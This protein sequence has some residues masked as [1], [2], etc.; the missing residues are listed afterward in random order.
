[1]QTANHTHYYFLGIG[2]IGMSA[3]ARYLHHNGKTIAGYDKTA[4]SLC[5]QLEK[6]GIDI[7]YQDDF[8]SIPDLF[9]DIETACVIYTPA[10][11]KDFGELFR[12]RESGI[13]LKKRAQLLG[14]ISRTMTCLAVAGTHG[15]TTTSA[16]LAHLLYESGIKMTAFLGGI[17]ND[18]QTNYLSTGTDVMVVEADEFDR[19]F[20]NLTADIAGI[21]AIDADHLDIYGDEAEFKKTFQ[22]FANTIPKGNLLLNEQVDLQGRF[23]GVSEGEYKASDIF[24]KDGAYHFTL[25]SPQGSDKDWVLKLPGRHNLSNAI[26][27]I[28]MALEYGADIALLKKALATFPGVDRRFTYRIDSES[29]V[30]I[31]DYAHHPTEIEAAYKAVREM[32]PRE[33][34]TAVF[35][36]HL[37]SR[38]RDFEAEFIAKLAAFDYLALLDI[39]PARELPIEGVSAYNL[40]QQINALGG[41]VQNTQ[42]IDKADL[43]EY[44]KNR[45]TRIV[46]MIGAG[47]IG[48]EIQ[49]VTEHFKGNQS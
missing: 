15:K 5:Q 12:F 14:D 38:T 46:L 34:I 22:D 31:D 39:Y 36:P 48:V 18:Y 30:L 4:T 17:L 49:K 40:V 28:A 1:M 9:K 10:I 33:K 24:I 32:Y 23:V 35:Q 11:P 20:M 45:G 27:A 2:G 43:I 8:S 6:E 13:T 16:I 37:F 19:S 7:H 25:I 44:I 26:L 21:T 41:N 3:L 47:D 29:L 42:V